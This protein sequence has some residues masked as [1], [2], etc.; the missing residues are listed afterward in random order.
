MTPTMWGTA[1]SVYTTD[2][3]SR[4]IGLPSR[5]MGARVHTLGFWKCLG[6]LSPAPEDPPT[7]PR[8][9]H[10]G[11]RTGLTLLSS[12]TLKFALPSSGEGEDGPSLGLVLTL[13]GLLP[14]EHGSR[15]TGP[16]SECRLYRAGSAPDAFQGP[17]VFLPGDATEPHTCHQDA[18]VPRRG[19][20]DPLEQT[21][22]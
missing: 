14:T 7:P 16:G 1:A 21:T 5:E 18:P 13:A 9:P 12:A 19:L 10:T 8:R 4:A 20:S 15:G 17:Q 22:P 3:S 11:R 6:Q 2:A